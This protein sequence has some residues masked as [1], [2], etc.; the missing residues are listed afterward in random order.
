M[1]NSIR[2]PVSFQIFGQ[3]YNVEYDD[4][5]RRNTEN[6]GS[7]SPRQNKITLEPDQLPEQL[8]QC[9]LHELTHA[10][11]GELNENEL[12]HNEKFVDT[13]A[14]ALHQVLQSAKYDAG[15]R[16]END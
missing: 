3:T 5:L 7:C 9:F 2:I 4:T 11:L 15:L 8:E 13:F 10:I 6:V 1:K 14:G 12:Y 16:N